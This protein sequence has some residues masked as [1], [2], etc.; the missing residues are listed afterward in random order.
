MFDSLE[1]QNCWS[2]GLDHSDDSDWSLAKFPMGTTEPMSPTACPKKGLDFVFMLPWMSVL[3]WYLTPLRVKIA[4]PEGCW[5][6][7]TIGSGQILP[8]GTL[9]THAG[10]RVNMWNFT[11]VTSVDMAQLKK[12]IWRSTWGY[13]A[14]IGS[15]QIP[16]TRTLSTHWR[17]SQHVKLTDC[18]W[19]QLRLEKHIIWIWPKLAIYHDIWHI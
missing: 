16:P 14:R 11:N 7:G 18:R 10:E 17:E 15:G 5:P 19:W 13:I 3:R 1:T 2:I 6:T 12:V 4:G 9:S 8:T